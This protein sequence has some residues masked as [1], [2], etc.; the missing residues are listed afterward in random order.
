M[1]RDDFFVEGGEEILHLF[2]VFLAIRIGFDDAF[3][4]INACAK[5][6]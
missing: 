3:D 6:T 2:F 4:L 5:G 1:G